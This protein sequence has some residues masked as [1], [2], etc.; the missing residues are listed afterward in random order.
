MCVRTTPRATTAQQCLAP[1]ARKAVTHSSELAET[2][3]MPG[4]PYELAC[5]TPVRANVAECPRPAL[6]T[7]KARVEGAKT[8]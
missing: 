8:L 3:Q 2:K 1:P 5:H 4:K 7:H 6:E